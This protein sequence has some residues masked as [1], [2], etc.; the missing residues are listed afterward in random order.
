MYVMK[1]PLFL[2]YYISSWISLIIC[3][4]FVARRLKTAELQRVVKFKEFSIE[5]FMMWLFPVGVWILQ[6]EINHIFFKLENEN[7]NEMAK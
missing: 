2:L 6:P 3:L 5:L 1:Q 7:K 4:N